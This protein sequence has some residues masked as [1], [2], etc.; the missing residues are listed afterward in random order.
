LLQFAA[1]PAVQAKEPS[2]SLSTRPEN[3]R[4]TTDPSM[5]SQILKLRERIGHSTLMMEAH[6]ID[7]FKLTRRFR[8]HEN[9]RNFQAGHCVSCFAFLLKKY[10]NCFYWMEST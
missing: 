3:N 4:W 1:L 7:D 8:S 10:Q 9:G 5:S 2:S 6:E